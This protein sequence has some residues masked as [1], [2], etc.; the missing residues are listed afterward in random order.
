MPTSNGLSTWMYL[1]AAQAWPT[2]AFS[3]SASASTSVRA[4]ARRRPRRRSSP[5]PPRRSGVGE[6][7]APRAWSGT[8]R[9]AGGGSQHVDRRRRCAS[10]SATSPGQGQHGDTGRAVR[11]V[12]GGSDHAAVPAPA[13]EIISQNTEHSTEQPVRVRL[14]E[15]LGA[16]LR[17]RDVRRDRQH[18][19]ARPVGVVEPVDQVQVARSAGAGADREPA[20]QLP[21][22]R[23]PRTRRPPRAARAPSR[24]RRRRRAPGGPRRRPG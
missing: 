19:D 4:P 23:P 5:S 9:G 1:L 24:C 3:R 11:V 6:R 13:V 20:G 10:R 14:L 21:P 18:R 7:L 15:E 2:G 12:D 22:R 17:A 8:T 16:D